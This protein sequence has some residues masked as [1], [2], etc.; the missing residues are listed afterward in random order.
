MCVAGIISG[1]ID[2]GFGIAGIAPGC[3]LMR[4]K[5]FDDYGA[6]PWVYPRV[7]TFSFGMPSICAHAIEF[8]TDNGAHVINGSWS[9]D[10]SYNWPV[11]TDALGVA[12]GAGV[13]PVF[14][15][16]NKSKSAVGFP[17]NSM[18]TIAVGAVQENGERWNYS[19]YGYWLDLVAP[20]GCLWPAT[21]GVYT[22]DLT[23]SAGYNP[24]YWVDWDEFIDVNCP[25][26]AFDYVCSFGGTSAAAPQVAAIVALVL[27]RRPDYLDM[28]DPVE[29]L[30]VIRDIL[31][32]S[33]VDQIGDPLYDT[34]GKD[35]Y[36]GYG[37]ANAF[38]AL[39]SVS[40]GDANNS[41]TINI[42]DLIYIEDYLF[43]GGPE[44]VPD[45]LMGDCNCSGTVNMSD[46]V[47]LINYLFGIPL[48][49]PPVTPC[50]QY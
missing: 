4:L 16:G 40:R 26:G 19:N 2:N 27:S 32:Y 38:R 43:H 23:D 34:P 48:G 35:N 28:E 1:D 7:D 20:S 44:P 9:W 41:G 42:S 11:V 33:A 45:R 36:Y 3:K 6:S 50:F 47:Y 24:L 5:I 15:S 37:L 49:P 46:V 8:A 21:P 14:S 39:L 12:T 31:W 18:H 30:L 25:A 17:A 22:L 29:R 13:I 10:A